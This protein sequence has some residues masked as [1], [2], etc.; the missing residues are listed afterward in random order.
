[1]LKKTR[2]NVVPANGKKRGKPQKY[3]GGKCFPLSISAPVA[4]VSRLDRLAAARGV[5][6]SDAAVGLIVAGLDLGSQP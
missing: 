2:K 4:V 3:G 6:R 1:M 5:S